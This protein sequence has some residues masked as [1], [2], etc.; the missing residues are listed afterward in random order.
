MSKYK[1]TRCPAN[2]QLVDTEFE[3]V[4]IKNMALLNLVKK[5]ASDVEGIKTDVA[6]LKTDVA[7]L[8]VRVTKLE[9]KLDTVIKLNNLRTE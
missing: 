7:D 8:K 1:I 4:I 9:T 2:E 6:S 3:A 5:I